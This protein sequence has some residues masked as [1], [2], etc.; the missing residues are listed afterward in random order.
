M[1]VNKRIRGITGVSSIIILG[2]LVVLYIE[3][4][5]GKWVF[6]DNLLW[7]MMGSSVFAWLVAH[8]TYN[9]ECA[10]KKRKIIIDILN[11]Q[12]EVKYLEEHM[13]LVDNMS[14]ELF[15]ECHE[16]IAKYI[17]SFY[18]MLNI[19]EYEMGSSLFNNVKL[20]GYTGVY[21]EFVII[22]RHIYNIGKIL[23][24]SRTL[25]QREKVIEKLN[26]LWREEEKAVALI[27]E[28]FKKEYGKN[29][30]KI[31]SIGLL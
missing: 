19:F 12:K 24:E 6:I 31:K 14:P 8:I 16:K 28:I 25:E 27:E 20:E 17:D 30:A 4:I 5:N 29:F 18:V 9:A 15:F 13:P 7:S 22:N 2:L 11:I 21:N 23:S 3:G 26:K 10:N 1:L